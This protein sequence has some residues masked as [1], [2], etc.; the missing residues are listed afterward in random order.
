[1]LRTA[2]KLP[3]PNY[4]M[5]SPSDAQGN[6]F[7][8]GAQNKIRFH[9]DGSQFPMISPH[10][11]YLTFNIQ[12]KDANTKVQFNPN[13]NAGAALVVKN[14]KI[15]LNNSLAEEITEYNQ[16]AHIRADYAES[17]D[18]KLIGG[19]Y[20]HNL[21]SQELLSSG[22][23]GTALVQNVVKCVLQLDLSGIFSS[24]TAFSVMAF[25]SIQ[26]EIELDDAYKVLAKQK[27]HDV[28]PCENVTTGGGGGFTELILQP[29]F[30]PYDQA[31]NAVRIQDPQ[32][33]LIPLP[34]NNNGAPNTLSLES[35]PFVVN[36]RVNIVGKRAA[37]NAAANYNDQ[38]ITAISYDNTGTKPRIKLTF[39][40][41]ATG[42]NNDTLYDI[43]VTGSLGNDGNAYKANY[44][45]TNPEFALRVLDVPPQFASAMAS[46]VAAGAFSFDMHTFTNYRT[47]ISAGLESYTVSI[48][49]RS[50]RAK[51]ILAF[52]R[53][54]GQGSSF[55][56]AGWDWNGNLN[57]IKDYQWQYGN[58]RRPDRPVQLKNMC[59]VEE[60]QSQEH[61]VEIDKAIGACPSMATADLRNYAKNFI[62]GRSS[63]AYGSSE[64]F[65]QYSEILIY[66]N[67]FANQD[68]G[69]GGAV[70]QESIQWNN[71]VANTRRLIATPSGIPEIIY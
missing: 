51:S 2:Q 70:T 48:P 35:C 16:L 71:F 65:S 20:K 29:V 8:P 39:A 31:A 7:S 49:S 67:K 68:G 4:S 25:E 19:V 13:S 34:D 1:M 63:S 46:R 52:P 47:T 62:I 14:L 60:Y 38:Q 44:Q 45:V 11:S 43:T 53:K 66:I 21:G 6:V 40:N 61:I 10:E 18:R 42:N 23:A 30:N 9:I 56:K 3:I 58:L 64:D 17:P 59:R 32:Y 57:F 54:T 28:V 36:E 27:P 37:N 33:N 12:V 69:T 22:G 24:R 5:L 15:F 26:V 41:I 50:T 55:I